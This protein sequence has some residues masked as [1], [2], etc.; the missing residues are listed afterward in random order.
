MSVAIV[1]GSSSGLGLALT[2]HILRNTNLTVYALTHQSSSTNVRDRI[3]SNLDK[4]KERLTVL[5]EIDVR[6]ERGLEKAAETVRHREGKGCVRL[7]AC[8]AGVLHPEKS[9]GVIDL[10][11]ALST[12]QIN[13]LGHLLTYRHFVPLIPNKREFRSLTTSWHETEDPARGLVS[14]G[15]S[16][17]F[18]LSA[19]VGSISDNER[20][21]WYSYRASKAALNQVIRCLDHA[22][23][24]KSSSAIAV[25]Y[26]PGTVLTSFT[27]PIIGKDAKPDLEH[28]RLTVD[29]AIQHMT[30]VMGK[31]NRT[32]EDKWGGRCWDWRG[33]RVEW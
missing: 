12:F 25:G 22:L 10:Q 7:V 23:V 29:Q 26:H 5:S 20:G 2:R 8:L 6:E 21:G 33:S 16:L 13:T 24:N 15:N 1:Q 28:G 17:C 9:L 4:G 31:V 18:S 30:D 11:A 3:T 19:R 27:S 32:E 14:G